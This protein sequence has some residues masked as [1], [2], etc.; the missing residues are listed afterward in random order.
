MCLN[1][2]LLPKIVFFN[3]VTIKAVFCG[4][5]TS[6]ISRFDLLLVTNKKIELKINT[7]TNAI[8]KI[9]FEYVVIEG[10]IISLSKPIAILYSALIH[11]I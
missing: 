7:I 6:S 2:S 3:L 5:K 10:I 4:K 11:K 8:N 1:T 9:L